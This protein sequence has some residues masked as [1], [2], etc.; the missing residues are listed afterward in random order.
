MEARLDPKRR[1][2]G[3]GSSSVFVIIRTFSFLAEP[4]PLK[5]CGCRSEVGRWRCMS[6]AARDATRL[7]RPRKGHARR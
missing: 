6:L 2:L 7:D 5:G 1:C 4:K 3:S